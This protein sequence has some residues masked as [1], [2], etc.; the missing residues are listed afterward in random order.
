MTRE[1]VA[2]NVGFAIDFDNRRSVQDLGL[3][4]RSPEQTFGDHIAQLARDQLLQA[5]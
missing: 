4:Y 1:F 3:A 2:K 5:P